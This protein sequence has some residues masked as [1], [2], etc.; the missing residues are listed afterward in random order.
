M[1]RYKRPERGTLKVNQS[2]VGEPLQDK[3]ARMTETGVGIEKITPIIS[4][5]DVE[6]Y[7]NVRT[8]KWDI[9]MEATSKVEQYLALKG[10]EVT[11]DTGTLKKA[12]E[13]SEG[14]EA[15]SE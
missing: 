10:Q 9:A 15:K 12:A 6:A 4:T 2:V 11:E 13:G 5:N 3:L 7:T 14:E 1:K 8:D